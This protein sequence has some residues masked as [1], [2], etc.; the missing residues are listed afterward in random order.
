MIASAAGFTGG[1]VR[2]QGVIFDYDGSVIF[3][4]KGD[5]G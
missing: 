2:I 1:G 3:E 4:H 5:D